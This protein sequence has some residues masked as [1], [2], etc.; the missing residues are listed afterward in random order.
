MKKS[1]LLLLAGLLSLG[2]AGCDNAPSGQSG[3][4][5]KSASASTGPTDATRA[6]PNTMVCLSGSELES[7]QPLLPQL[8]KET[9]VHLVLNSSGTLTSVEKLQTG[10]NGYDCGWFSHNKYLMLDNRVKGLVVA[11]ERIMSSPVILGIKA[12]KAKEL[13][14][15]ADTTTWADVAKAANAGTFTFAMTSPASSNTGMSALIGVTTA[16]SGAESAID[17]KAIAKVEL[18]GF[19]KG[20][21]MYADSSGWLTTAFAKDLANP[22]GPDGIINYE[23]ELLRLNAT[24]NAHLTLIYP[25]EGIITAD[26][27]LMLFNAAKKAQYDKVTAFFKRDDIQKSLMAS[28]YRRPVSANVNADQALFGDHLLVEVGFPGKMSTIDSL[29]VSYLDKQRRPA[30]VYFVLDT[31]GSMGSNGGIQQLRTAMAGLAGGDTS[32]TGR[33][34]QFREREHVTVV[35]F[36]SAVKAQNTYNISQN[37][38]EKA[39][40]LTKLATYANNLSAEGGTAI[41]DAVR[42]AYNMA[43]ENQKLEPGYVQSIVVMTDGVSNQGMG[44]DEFDAFYQAMPATSKTIRI[45][46]V[47]FGSDAST[48]QIQKLADLTGGAVLDGTKSLAAVFKKIRGYQ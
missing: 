48:G 2:L 42:S 13:H 32:V 47:L 27:P 3:N 19:G 24:Q 1:S 46:G 37:P 33:F 20:H 29:L 11:S 18:S 25:K 5:G 7:V 22:K 21:V 40:E 43:V 41:F 28:T 10:A 8:E 39:A 30:H 23:S 38:T 6:D 44:P 35:E 4:S 14:W 45:F 16:L 12:A 17:E 31:S 15:S 36:A 9:G 26:Y 34:A